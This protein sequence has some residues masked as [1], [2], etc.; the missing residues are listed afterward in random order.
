[1]DLVTVLGEEAGGYGDWEAGVGGMAKVR[2]E[3]QDEV[4]GNEK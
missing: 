1:M 4:G 2:E 3:K